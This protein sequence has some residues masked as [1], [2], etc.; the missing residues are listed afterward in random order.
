MADESPD[1]KVT[2]EVL[3]VSTLRHDGSSAKLLSAE[4]VIT[5]T[6]CKAN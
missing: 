1:K 4:G 3:I 5:D 6:D 2:V